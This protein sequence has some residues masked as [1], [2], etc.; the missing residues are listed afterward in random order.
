MITTTALRTGRWELVPEAARV[1]FAVRNPYVFGGAAMA[2]ACGFGEE[3][4]GRA[5][6]SVRQKIK[7]RRREPYDA[8]QFEKLT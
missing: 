5:P 3:G 8:S 1:G 7:R 2:L 4:L 6:R